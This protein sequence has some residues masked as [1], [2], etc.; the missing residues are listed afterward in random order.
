MTKINSWNCPRTSDEDGW[1]L[2][3]MEA[4]R[5]FRSSVLA[6]NFTTSCVIVTKEKETCLR[7]KKSER[8]KKRSLFFI[9]RNHYEW[10]NVENQR[11]YNILHYWPH[12]IVSKPDTWAVIMSKVFHPN[13][14]PHSDG[15]QACKKKN[16]WATVYVFQRPKVWRVHVRIG[17]QTCLETNLQSS[18]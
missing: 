5:C 2:W 16:K 18:N 12:G 8:G 7:E 10:E 3:W 15:W 14:L 11:S 1:L 17:Q 9:Y 6:V 4:L 13:A